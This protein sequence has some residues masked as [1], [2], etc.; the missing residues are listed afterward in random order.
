MPLAND[1]GR[2]AISLHLSVF[3][4]AQPSDWLGQVVLE[5]KDNRANEPRLQVH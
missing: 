4:G 3:A 5:D 2:K 1:I